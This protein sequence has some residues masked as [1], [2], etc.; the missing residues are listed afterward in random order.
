MQSFFEWFEQ[1]GI[2][3]E[4]PWLI[5]GKGPSFSKRVQFDLSPFLCLSL[6]HAVREQPVKLAHIID[7]DVVDHLSGALERNT[8]YLVM[9]WR[10][11]VNNDPGRYTLAD[12][13]TSHPLLRYLEEQG[14]LLWYN[15]SSAKPR[16]GSPIVQARY[17]SAEAALNLLAL[18]GVRTVRSLGI[19]GGSTYSSAF[20]DLRG[21][22]LLANGRMSFDDQFKEIAKTILRVG[23]DYAPLDIQSPIRVFVAT[24]EAQMLAVKVLEYS[25]KK[26]TSMSTLVFPLHRSGIDIPMPKDPENHPR[27]PFSFQRF[28]IP[29]LMN[30]RGRA[31]YLDSDMQVFKDLRALWTLPMDGAQLL[32]V[33][34][35]SEKTGRRPQFSVMLLDCEALDWR[36]NEIIQALD[37]HRLTYEDLMYNM[38]VAARVS[39]TID[40]SWN[41][42]ER[43]EAGS[44]ALLHYTDMDIQPWISRENPN[45]YL[46]VRDLL[47]AIEDGFLKKEYIEDHVQ[48]GFVRPSL[49]WQIEHRVEDPL[50][51]PRSAIV[52]DK[53]FRPPYLALPRHSGTP[54]VSATAAARA[55]AQRKLQRSWAYRLRRSFRECF[56]AR[57]S[58]SV[59][60]AQDRLHPTLIYRLQHK[61]R[62]LLMH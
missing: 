2:P 3:R 57:I 12:L 17:F 30:W 37:E 36:I 22:T 41:S 61:I 11:H 54:W 34:E 50:A 51:L 45:G 24:T 20:N 42:L 8:E 48:R 27:T 6:N 7:L 52:L 21:K 29:Q 18:A 13:A 60:A 19:D 55:L 14:R 31:I 9:P 35:P 56:K 43:Y 15:L 46:W 44:T 62:K 1:S 59:D 4:R 39:A 40:P 10:P 23:I 53:D 5:F 58:D 26:H 33:R 28:I 25:I 49:L 47:A 32:A 38:R 16:A